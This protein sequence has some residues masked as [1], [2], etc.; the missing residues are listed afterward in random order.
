MRQHWV[1]TSVLEEEKAE[2]EVSDFGSEDG[3]LQVVEEGR[4]TQGR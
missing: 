4:N 3:E 1:Y 2:R